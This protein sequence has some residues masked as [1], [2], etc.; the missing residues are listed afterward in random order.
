MSYGKGNDEIAWIPPGGIPFQTLRV[1]GRAEASNS[2][3]IKYTL[4]GQ[5]EV[6]LAVP[7][8]NAWLVVPGPGTLTGLRWTRP[9]IQMSQHLSVLLNWT[10]S[11]SYGTPVWNTVKF[12]V[13]IKGTK[14]CRVL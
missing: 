2:E 6:S 4:Q 5:S 7:D 10:A 8:T 12:G 13:S 9:V 11:S 3:G 1:Y 14:C